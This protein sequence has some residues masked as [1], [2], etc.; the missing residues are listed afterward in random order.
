MPGYNPQG[1]SSDA[2]SAPTPYG[3]GGQPGGDPN[4]PNGNTGYPGAGNVPG[5]QPAKPLTLADKAELAFRQGR[6]QDAI[7]YLY[8]HGVTADADAAK[9]VLGKMGWITPLKRPAMA[10]RWGIAVEYT[11]PRGYNGNI[12]P[13]G[14]TQNVPIKG[15]PGGQAPGGQP[16]GGMGDGGMGQGGMGAGQGSP[17]LQQL[18]GE[19]GQKVVGQLQ[20]RIARGDFGQVMASLGKA[21]A[22]GAGGAVPGG[23]MPGYMAPGGGSDMSGAGMASGFPGSAPGGF[24]GA[25]GQPQA[26]RPTD[27]VSLAPGIVLLGLVS[28][29]DLREKGQKAGVDAVCVFDVVVTVNPRTQLIKNETTIHLHDLMQAKELYESKTLNNIQ[30]QIERVEKKS[31]QDPVDKELESLFKFVDSNWRLGQ[32]PA[33]LQ[34]DHVLNRLRILLGESHENPLPVLAEA[35]MYQTRGLLQDNH[36]LTA[37]QKLLGDPDGTQLVNGSEE[38]KLQLVA[39]WLPKEP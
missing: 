24:G 7:Q 36:F 27:A 4:N 18:T 12:Y 25:P 17:Q 13:I 30:V 15:A 31:D 22:A 33:G 3:M 28:A 8:A 10:V 9:E 14:T 32:L 34:A 2:S 23:G 16:P 19:L 5:Q 1:A 35:R 21:S 26:G 29:K 6:D 37:C 11:A 39:K 20:E 38:E